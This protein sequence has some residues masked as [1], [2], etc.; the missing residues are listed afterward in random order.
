VWVSDVAVQLC[1]ADP[2]V[3]VLAFGWGL[4]RSECYLFGTWWMLLRQGVEE[5]V[6]APGLADCLQ[7][8][9]LSRTSC[10]YSFFEFLSVWCILSALLDRLVVL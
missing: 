7:R 6:F 9:G 4:R 1:H 3:F 5:A 8:C 10:L 2:C